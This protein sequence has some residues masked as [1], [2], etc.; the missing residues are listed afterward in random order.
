MVLTAGFDPLRDEALAYAD[1]LEAAGVPVRRLHYPDMIHGFTLLR[2]L[3]PKPT[4]RSRTARARSWPFSVHRPRLLQATFAISPPSTT[5]SMPVMKE[6][7]SESRKSAASATFSGCPGRLSG[8]RSSIAVIR[9]G[10][11]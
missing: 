9:A 3:L 4:P 10:F 8:V 2:G 11:W 6:A 7:A 1:A 5:R